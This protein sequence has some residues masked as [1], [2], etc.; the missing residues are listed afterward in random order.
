VFFLIDFIRETAA[1]FLAAAP[2]LL[3]GFFLAGVLRVIVPRR[4][5]IAAMG[6]RDFRSVFLAS[7]T[8]IPLPLCSCSVLP[9]AA[10]LREG[11]ASKGATVSFLISTPET[12]VDS[13]SV[14]YALLDPIM[15]VARPLAAFGT[16]MIAGASV[17][18]FDREAESE[19]SKPN[20]SDLP[21]QLQ[22]REITVCGKGHVGR[23]PVCSCGEQAHVPRGFGERLRAVVSYAYGD[24]LD[25]LAS[26]LVIG[27]A[28]S[29]LIGAL[30]PDGALQNPSLQGFPSM[31]AM[32]LIGIPLY[33][34]ATSSTPI[35]AMLILKGLSPGAAMVFLLVG[36]ATNM[37]TLT[38]VF[39]TLGRKSALIY[40]ISVGVV[41]LLAGAIVNDIYASRG[42]DPVAVV[43]S[44][45]RVLP[46]WLS[47]LA[48]LVLLGLLIRSGARTG[49]VRQW[50]ENLARLGK[51]LGLDL[52]G[53][54]VRAAVVGILLVLYLLTGCSIVGPGETGWVVTFGKARRTIEEPGLV[55]HWPYP[56]SVLEKEQPTLVRSIDRGF[57]Q[58]QTRVPIDRLVGTA[59]LER[60]MIREAE[61]ATGDENLIA[62]R[63]SV[64]YTVADAFTHHFR[65]DEP[66]ALVGSF[67]EFALRRIMAYQE[68]DS[69]LVNHRIELSRK[70]E[71]RLR[72]ELEAINAGIEVMRVDLLD[73]HAPREVHFAFRDVASAMED[74]HR[75]IRQAESYRNRVVAE[76]RGQS[77]ATQARARGDSARRV[78]QATGQAY[79]FTAL[80][81][82]CRPAMEISRLRMQLDVAGRAL[83]PGSVILSLIDLPLDL[84][85]GKGTS[86]IDWNPIPT[87]KAPAPS[88]E[89]PEEAASQETWREKMRRMQED[90][91]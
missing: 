86:P 50:R 31:L 25:H 80:D 68:T 19:A 38:V 60:E 67:A 52:G 61:I 62:L 23:G 12:G 1:V 51:P 33:V 75:F 65:L 84:W 6:K 76:A 45:G 39:K 40:L 77:F 87:T 89:E 47:A 71:R 36:P 70:V 32:L 44:A 11:G 88:S 30:I 53:R 42:I 41:S 81:Q 2:F 3:F 29:G 34:C 17:N 56:I 10:G 48:A 5:L 72:Q 21:P 59:P 58:D 49:M 13:I 69:I 57:R 7:L 35:A 26:W 20:N 37:T 15:T 14:T 54:P 9:T 91:R 66:E 78:A 24:L 90:S 46:G 63:Y 83:R 28:L 8:G 55:I 43:G 64:Q 85:L 4:W 82:A 73:V 74:N 79:G 27:M 18:L 22:E 16:A